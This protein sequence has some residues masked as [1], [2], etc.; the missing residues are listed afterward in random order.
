VVERK[1]D[2]KLPASAISAPLPKPTTAPTLTAPQA[3]RPFIAWGD[4]QNQRVHVLVRPRPKT[5]AELENDDVDETTWIQT[6]T[7]MGDAERTYLFDGVLSCSASNQSVH[8]LAG[9]PTLMEGV[10]KGVNACMLLYGQTNSGK[11]HTL[12]GSFVDNDH[13]RDRMFVDQARQE[14]GLLYCALNSLF[15]FLR[16]ADGDVCTLSLFEVYNEEVHDLFADTMH[17]N[18]SGNNTRPKKAQVLYDPI[19]DGFLIDGLTETPFS[20]LSSGLALLSVGLTRV[21]L[22]TSH[23]NERSSRAHTICKVRVHKN[24]FQADHH[25]TSTSSEICF[26]DLAGSE[27]LV[28]PQHQQAAL[29]ADISDVLMSSLASGSAPSKE[30]GAAAWT[31]DFARVKSAHH[32]S[33]TSV[34]KRET[35]NINLSLTSLKKCILELSRQQRQ[36]QQQHLRDG[37]TSF[38][39]SGSIQARQSARSFAGGFIPFRDS[40]LTKILKTS[41]LGNSRVLMIC[42]VSLGAANYRETKATLAFGTLAKSVTTSAVANTEHHFSAQ[43]AHEKLN[44]LEK[45]NSSLK[46]QI[47]NLEAVIMAHTREVSLGSNLRGLLTDAG[48]SAPRESLPQ[49]S[50][51]RGATVSVSGPSVDASHLVQFEASETRLAQLVSDT[52]KYLADG[53]RAL[54]LVDQST[55]LPL[56]STRGPL[57]PPLTARATQ[58]DKVAKPSGTTL[59]PFSRT[60]SSTT[61]RLHPPSTQQMPAVRSV[62]LRLKLPQGR[63]GVEIVVVDGSKQYR[64]KMDEMSRAILGKNFP[65]L[66]AAA[67]ASQAEQQPENIE[68][69][70]M[71]KTLA[72]VSIFPFAVAG[73]SSTSRLNKDPLLTFLCFEE[74]DLEA[75]V[76]ALGHLSSQTL[77]ATP[78]SSTIIRTTNV[79]SSADVAKNTSA[80]RPPTLASPFLRAKASSVQSLQA[81]RRPPIHFS[82]DINTIARKFP[83]AVKSGYQQ[84]QP[85]GKA[86]RQPSFV[87]IPR[88][89]HNSNFDAA[90]SNEEIP[91]DV[92]LL[93]AQLSEKELLLCKQHNIDLADYLLTRSYILGD[94]K[95]CSEGIK[96]S[97]LVSLYDIRLSCPVTLYQ[98]FAVV[99]FLREQRLILDL[100]AYLSSGLTF[101]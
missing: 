49:A 78:I 69:T 84:Q 79:F 13:H 29:D 99:K 90:D 9:V 24:H 45:E 22:G 35:A 42:T 73:G 7:S 34:S 6:A 52:L 25:Q 20:D 70:F 37:S 30:F 28:G 83:Y 46:E 62:I 50:L 71:T 56:T 94:S 87:V 40:V 59:Q 19:S 12:F 65:E 43:A 38:R 51:V 10:T 14:Q 16:P 95:R 63:F 72:S 57:Q 97:M 23:I 68:P 81:A 26:V 3:E 4:E 85:S 33:K 100:H 96:H 21:T 15:R 32:I 75:W 1:E 98:A 82:W 8:E 64:V 88:K 74:S 27:S 48:G 53:V 101:E 36:Q 60:R 61:P 41:L 86:P 47:A 77:G 55:S 5:S 92:D 67:A 11:T 18:E 39:K 44:V 76:I 58:K 91:T 93:L 17:V 31:D 54:V 89:N 2:A 80:I 66:R